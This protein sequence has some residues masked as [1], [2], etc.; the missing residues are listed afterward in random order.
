MIQSHNKYTT[1]MTKFC[2]TGFGDIGSAVSVCA[3]EQLSGKE[4][5]RKR[6]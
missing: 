2:A 1:T 3:R 4:T 6:W 5:K